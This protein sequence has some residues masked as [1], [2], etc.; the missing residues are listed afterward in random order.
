LA[1]L[2]AVFFRKD[3]GFPAQ[4]LNEMLTFVRNAKGKPEAMDKKHDDVIMSA[5]IG[6]AILQEQGRYVE[7]KTG[8][9]GFSHMREMFGE[10]NNNIISH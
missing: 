5:A 4:L 7:D 6:Y 8:G 1:A 2:K 3:K 9:D 10:S